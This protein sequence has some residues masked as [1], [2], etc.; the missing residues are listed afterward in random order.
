MEES[1]VF[2]GLSMT[3]FQILF[4]IKFR[5][6]FRMSSSKL[7]AFLGLFVFASVFSAANLSAQGPVVTID[8][9]AQEEDP[10]PMPGADENGNLI[11]GG[12]GEVVV[13]VQNDNHV[14]LKCMGKNITNLSG[15]GQHVDGFACGIDVDGDGLADF[16][17]TDSHVTISKS[18]VASMTCKYTF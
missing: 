11:F 15:S 14:I 8:M 5:K 7:I 4:N 9:L 12:I 13:L 16:V 3:S 6:V 10:C 17:T 1:S 2:P 18:G